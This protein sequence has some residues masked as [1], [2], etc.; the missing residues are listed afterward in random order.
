M[1]YVDQIG[2]TLMIEG[3]PKRI[4]SLV[5]SQT[6][7][8]VDLG[9]QKTIVGITKFCVHPNSIRKEKT[10]VGGTKKVDYEKIRAL[11][12]DIV[13]CNKEENT[14][15]IVETLE[16]EYTV[17]VSDIFSIEDAVRMIKQY[18]EIFQEENR[19]NKIIDAIQAEQDS[20]EA[21]VK[22]TPKRKV[23]YFI[24]KDPWVVVG[25]NTFID[26]VL[27]L[28]NFENI[29]GNKNRYPE[30]SKEEIKSFKEQD[31]ILLSSEPFPFSEKHILE[32]KKINTTA[33]IILVDGEYFSWYGSRLQGAFSYFKALHKSINE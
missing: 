2:R 6:E 1:K 17:H 24:W 20:F 30:I 11:K 23:A 7:L 31:L 26:H 9:L 29:Y 3:V 25:N 5:P 18:G 8:L 4:I 22:N 15:E 14:K 16:K 13:L 32:I 33:K 10:I 27:R 21:Y 19:A 28:N 12:P